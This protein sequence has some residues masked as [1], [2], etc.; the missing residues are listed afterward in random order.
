MLWNFSPRD[1]PSTHT[2]IKGRVDGTSWLRARA[3]VGQE[4]SKTQRRRVTTA[5]RK[6]WREVPMANYGEQKESNG[7]RKG[8]FAPCSGLSMY[9]KCVQRV[10]Q[11]HTF[12]QQ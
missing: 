1:L 4:D 11:E 12:F 5:G 2:C 8:L 9:T 10:T 7:K 3:G 6:G